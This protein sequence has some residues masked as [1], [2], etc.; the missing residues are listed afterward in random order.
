MPDSTIND[1]VITEVPTTC[2]DAMKAGYNLKNDLNSDCFVDFED[3]A[4][5]ASDWLQCVNPNIV[6]CKHPWE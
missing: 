2:W 3:F 1:I 4:L 5:L 6:E